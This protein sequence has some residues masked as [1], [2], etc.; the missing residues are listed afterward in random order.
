MR[1]LGSPVHPIQLMGHVLKEFPDVSRIFVVY[2]GH[3]PMAASLII[4]F[5]DTIENPWASSLRE[6]SHVSP[7]MLLYWSMLE[8]ACKNG[9]ARFDFQGT[10]GR[11]A[12]SIALALC[13]S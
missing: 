9:L 11:Q 8:Y 6:Y 5:K 1:D 7:N 10:M 13:F 12:K 3:R 2:Q 4:T